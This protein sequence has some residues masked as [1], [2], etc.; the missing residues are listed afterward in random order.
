MLTEPTPYTGGVLAIVITDEPEEPD[1][2]AVADLYRAATRYAQSID[3]RL[4]WRDENSADAGST[5]R[6][7]LDC[8]ICAVVA[9]L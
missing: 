8:P 6:D 7:H 1:E 3:A 4:V 5:C 9:V 2:E